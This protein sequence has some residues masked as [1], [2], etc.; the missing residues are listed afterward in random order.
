MLNSTESV[1]KS[2]QMIVEL[3]L[4]VVSLVWAC[5]ESC[6]QMIKKYLKRPSTCETSLAMK[7]ESFKHAIRL[8]SA[9]GL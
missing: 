8:L 6:I 4:I 5:A 1:K 3:V 7:I 9:I 2:R